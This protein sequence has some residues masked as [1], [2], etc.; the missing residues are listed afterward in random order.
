MEKS[1]SEP[2][3]RHEDYRVPCNGVGATGHAN[4]VLLGHSNK[5]TG[6]HSNRINLIIKQAGKTPGPGRY[7]AHVPWDRLGGNQFVKSERTIKQMN[8]VPAPD[9]YEAKDFAQTNVMGAR[10]NLSHHPRNDLQGRIAKGKKRSF[11]DQAVRHS[12]GVPGPG[13]FDPKPFFKSSVES[14]VRGTVSYG[15][16]ISKHPTRGNPEK[17]IGP[18]DYHLSWSQID[19]LP[20]KYTVPKDPCNNFID[21]A[22]RDT[23]VDRRG[24]KEMPGPGTYNLQDFDDSRTSRGTRLAQIRGITRCPISGYM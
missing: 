23:M 2:V 18:S 21:K 12:D 15:K 13:H 10:N 3:L 20:P 19:E 24:K 14:H 22:V 7:V 17:Q 1:S 9:L 11:L 6:E 5:D 4:R 16:E 8:K